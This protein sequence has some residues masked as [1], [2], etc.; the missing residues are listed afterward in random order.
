MKK[1]ILLLCL[2]CLVGCNEKKQKIPQTISDDKQ[3]TIEKENTNNIV[4]ENKK[5]CKKYDISLLIKKHEELFE[6]M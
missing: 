6:N 4:E 5:Y 2:I 3:N 1:V